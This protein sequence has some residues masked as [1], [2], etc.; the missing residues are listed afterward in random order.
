MNKPTPNELK[1]ASWPWYLSDDMGGVRYVVSHDGKHRIC[2]VNYETSNEMS[3]A[4]A[5][6]LTTAPELYKMEEA[7]LFLLK[8]QLDFIEKFLKDSD[9]KGRALGFAM[10][11]SLS[12]RI[13]I[14]QTEELLA[15]ARGEKACEDMLN[16]DNQ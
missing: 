7:K 16:A 3:E 12:H 15:R 13:I 11:V 8:M 10:V 6:L 2:T 9:V 5:A 14:K 1:I 4:H